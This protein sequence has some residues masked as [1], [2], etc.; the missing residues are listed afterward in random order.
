MR[1]KNRLDKKGALPKR[2]T[3]I[4]THPDAIAMLDG[5]YYASG[6]GDIS[7]LDEELKGLSS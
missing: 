4:T 1:V 7:I 3:Q 2:S 6:A 5:Q